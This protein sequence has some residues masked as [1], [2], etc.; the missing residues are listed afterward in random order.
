MKRLVGISLFI[1]WAVVVALLLAG[2]VFYQN[3]KSANNFNASGAPG[4]NLSMVG[5]TTLSLAEITKHNSASD[6]WLL[7]SNQVYDVT[8]YLSAHPGGVGVI[9]Q[10]CG[11]EATVPFQTKDRGRDHSS[12][13]YQLLGNYLLGSLNQTIGQPQL[14]GNINKTKTLTPSV[15]GG[16][17]N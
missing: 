13:A 11:Q 4:R 15:G 9:S 10:Y 7:I 5:T 6:C 2:L 12:Y 3:N 1:F 16:I 14:Q 17:D 8:N